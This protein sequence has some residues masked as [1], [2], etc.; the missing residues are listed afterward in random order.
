MA[1]ATTSEFEDYLSDLGLALPAGAAGLLNLATDQIDELVTNTYDVDDDLLPTDTDV[2][3]AL[4]KATIYQAH[5]LMVTNDPTGA[6]AGLSSA[7]T[8]QVSWTRGTRN[9]A[10]TEP[11]RWAPAA[12]GVLSTANL[13]TGVA[14]R[15]W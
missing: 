3:T 5:Y 13:V 12:V 6:L 4:R 10:N 8:G 1:Y 15:R 9:G 14:T 2:E 11:E 7:S